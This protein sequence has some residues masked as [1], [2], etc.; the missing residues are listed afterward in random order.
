MSV[1]S[2]R[3]SARERLLAAADELFYAEG[4]H[5][6]G[7]DRVIERAG[8]AKASLYSAFGNK[9]G[10][11]RAYLQGRHE[12]RQARILRRVHA[13]DDPR[14]RLLAVFDSLAESAAKPG[15][16]GCAFYNAG[17]EADPHGVVR[18]ESDASRAWT[19]QLFTDLAREAG[20]PDPAAL[21]AQLVILYDGAMVGARQD[22]GP[23]AVHQ[24]R[25]IA[26]AL[27]DAATG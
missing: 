5:T 11:V 6:V 9:D 21:A 18:E 2:P 8:V 23:A 1:A 24:A 19:R 12:E 10:L 17:A 27:L 3:R 25:V 22:P 4:V 20:A 7:I 15:F 16:R 14:D 13:H 26:A